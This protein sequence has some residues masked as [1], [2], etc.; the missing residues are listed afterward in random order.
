MVQ[1]LKKT[2]RKKTTAKK[3]AIISKSTK[4]ISAITVMDSK[5][6]PFELSVSTFFLL[7][8][9]V[10]ALCLDFL[11]LP[12]FLWLGPFVTDH[13]FLGLLMVGV[14]LAGY[15]FYLLPQ[16]KLSEDLNKPTAYALLGLILLTAGFLETDHLGQAFAGFWADSAVMISDIPSVVDMRQFH[17]VFAVGARPPF[18]SYICALVWWLFPFLKGMAMLRISSCVVSLTTFWLFYRLGREVSGKRLVGVLLAA[19]GAASKPYLIQIITG[20]GGLVL[21]FAVTLFL[22]FQFRVFKKPTLARYLQWGAAMAVG[23]HTYTSAVPWLPFL[24]LVNIVFVF[25]KR[26]SESIEKPAFAAATLFV[27]FYLLFY[28][29]HMAS[30]FHDNP[31]S[32]LWASNLWVWFLLQAGFLSAL[33]YGYKNS[34]ETGARLCALGLGLLLFGVLCYPLSLSGGATGRIAEESLLP[35][36]IAGLFS[37]NFFQLMEGQMVR[38]VMYVF[39]AGGER[40]DMNVLG[41]SFFDYQEAIVVLLGLIYAVVKPSRT[42]SFLILC[43][44]AGTVPYLLTGDHQSAKF[45]GVMPPALLLGSMALG[46]W[47]ESAWVGAWKTR[48]MGLLLVIGFLG[49][50]GW[51]VKAT[52]QRVYVKWWNEV[53]ND[54]VCIGREVDKALPDKRV[55]LTP[56]T[57]AHSGNFFDCATQAVLHDDQS[58][59]L[60]NDKNIISLWPEEK[61]KDVVVIVSPL[62]KKVVSRLKKEFPAAQWNSSWQYYQQSHN[63]IPFIYSVTIPAADIPDKPGKLFQF[64][65]VPDQYW[66]RMNYFYRL[67]F[68][69]GVIQ[70]ENVSPTLNPPP[71]NA[72]THAISARGQW[73]A[74]A[75][76]NYTFSMNSGEFSRIVVDEL[77]VLTSLEGDQKPVTKT[78]FLKKGNHMIQYITYL[79]TRG[80][81][82][83]VTVQNTDLDYKVVLGGMVN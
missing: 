69:G 25:W 36:T 76:G 47:I 71:V 79:L 17:L 34:K 46:D 53:Q 44:L 7:F 2:Q 57:V 72:A 33:I 19:F 15:G 26:H 50:W 8:A 68:R 48:W 38:I 81:F 22:L 52:H 5:Q 60:L 42:K 56:I 13:Y 27:L 67:C 12:S 23:I 6:N 24:V 43:V 1:T 83:D 62:M 3:S 66:F 10:L 35:K 9:G 45:C 51:E 30:V 78:V 11:Q 37:L 32:K 64:Q 58:V 59:Y 39:N 75:D 65:R 21:V 63:E 82:A 74:P 70:D 31:V 49:F 4:T 29:D 55:Y 80:N 73:V 54:D 14:G 41:D 77:V 20:Y 40:S 61:R 18:Y 16:E 28:V